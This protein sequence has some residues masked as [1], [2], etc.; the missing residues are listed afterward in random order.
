MRIG[1]ISDKSAPFFIGGY[2]TRILELAR[3]LGRRNEVRVFTSLKGSSTVV[4]GVHFSRAAP[5]TFLNR[6]AASRSFAHGAVYSACLTGNPMGR[7]IPDVLMVE[8]IPYTHLLTMEHWVKR[9]PVCRVLNV[10]E[11][12]VGYPLFSGF[13][14]KA[15]TRAMRRLLAIGISWSD[16]VVAISRATGN[17]LAG[18]YAVQA[19]LIV[20]MGVDRQLV[21][22]YAPRTDEPR[23]YDFTCM[24]R[25][26]SIK[27]VTDFL[28]ALKMLKVQNGWDGKAAI[29]GDGPLRPALEREARLLG[30]DAN[31]LFMGTVTEA[32]K[33]KVLYLTNTFVLP[34][35]RE[36]F[37][38]ATLEAMACGAPAIVAKPTFREVFGTS[39]FVE[40]GKTGLYFEVGDITQL[41]GCMD[42]ALRS[43]SQL[44]EMAVRAD[45]VA[46]TYDWDT[47][48]DGFERALERHVG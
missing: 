10:N 18:H 6:G 13:A 32:Q 45:A 37:S 48:V 8:A 22:S 38:V 27:R 42:F 9:L 30:I 33:Y 20:P 12:W 21:H 26:V 34:S 17:S 35:E 19:P 5:A 2:E 31:V 24:A 3:R 1:F 28:R 15:A 41:A 4:G 16:L 23:R 44:H 14:G 47:I 11:A 40:N 39:D 7:W 43:P 36:G 25:L 46:A 29:V